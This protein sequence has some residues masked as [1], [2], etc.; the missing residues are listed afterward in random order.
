MHF[1]DSSY[2]TNNVY[3]GIMVRSEPIF[4]YTANHSTATYAAFCRH[5]G[6]YDSRAI[7]FHDWN[8]EVIEAMADDLTGPWQGLRNTLLQRQG[9]VTGSIRVST[10]T[11]I[12]FLGKPL[13]L[14]DKLTLT[15][16]DRGRA[17]PRR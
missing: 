10:S 4:S 15:I 16:N 2:R 1:Q 6:R 9:H 8:E 11:G 3:S 17:G 5:Y 12:E 14:L 13:R 7:G